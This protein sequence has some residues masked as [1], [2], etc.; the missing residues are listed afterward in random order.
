MPER[1]PKSALPASYLP[2]FLGSADHNC[3]ECIRRKGRCDRQLPECG[4]CARNKRHC[5]YER[6]SKTPLTRKYLT[7][8]PP[9][10]AEDF[11]WD[12]Q[13][14][15][16]TAERERMNN[17]GQVD[18]DIDRSMAS[19]TVQDRGAGY[20]GLASGA[21]MLKL[22]LPDREK[23]GGRRALKRELTDQLPS[24]RPTEQ[25]WVPTPVYVERRIGEIDMDDAINAYFSLYH[26]FYPIIHEPSFRAQY[27]QVIGRPDGRTWNALAYIV[28]AIGVYASA[29]VPQTRDLDLFSAAKSNLS[30]DSLESG[31]VTLVQCLALMSNYLQKRNKP[32]SGYNYL[33]LAQHVAMGLGLHKEFNNWQISPLSHEIR[34]RVWWTLYALGVGA[35]I[36]FGRPL[37]WPTHGVEVA[38]PLNVDDR[39]LTNLSTSL[40][41][42][43]KGITT[44]HSIAAQ[45]RFHLATSDIYARVIST[46]IPTATELLRLDDERIENWRTL[47][48]SEED[49]VPQIFKLTR[50]I[51]NWRCANFRIIMY[52]PFLLRQ[53]LQTK[54]STSGDPDTQ[55]AINRCLHE[56]K[57]TIYSIQEAWTSCE[58]NTLCA[59]YMLYFLFQASMIPCV[60]MRNDPFS[61]LF[62]DWRQQ[63]T[64]VFETMASMHYI[65]QA[66]RECYDVL[67]RLCV[68]YVVGGSQGSG[69]T[70]NR[71]N[72]M[73]PT[74]E[75]P[76]TQLNSVYS[77]MW[78][79]ANTADTDMAIQDDS[80][81]AFLDEFEND[82]SFLNDVNG[83]WT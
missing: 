48:A 20:L 80:W 22:M 39:D 38:L 29:T 41:P 58:K 56:A 63:I 47:W 66:S 6:N 82:S 11:S 12:E 2:S 54:S 77:M 51:T 83:S 9:Y 71:E 25:G 28:A 73:Q 18:D 14:D 4:P 40:P 81:M 76:Q 78:P 1:K 42:P 3:N 52:R 59:W 65:N 37:S 5:L 32:N 49:A 16:E 62:A 8:L 55:R 53:V 17:P 79:N 44:H 35:M 10:G 64:T 26:L 61:P 36:T 70:P 15:G 31:N 50:Q 21:A 69:I 19:L 13:S 27:A 23:K 74:D 7:E 57:A 46:R 45:A 75:S 33:G 43:N 24:V 68:N 72:G 34:R 60:C 30:I 67:T